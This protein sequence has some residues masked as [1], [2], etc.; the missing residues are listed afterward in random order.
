MPGY[1]AFVKTIREAPARADIIAL[2]S[3]NNGITEFANILSATRIDHM[4]TCSVFAVRVDLKEWRDFEP[5]K[6]EFYFFDYPKSL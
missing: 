2:F 6:A 4:P 1:N 3:H 5:G